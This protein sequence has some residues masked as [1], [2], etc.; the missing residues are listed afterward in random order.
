LANESAKLKKDLLL[1]K[2]K[3]FTDIN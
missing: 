2:S 3:L 1:S